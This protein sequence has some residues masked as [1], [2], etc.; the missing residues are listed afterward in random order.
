VDTGL[1]EVL[2]AAPRL[3]VGLEGVANPE[4]VGN[5]FRNAVAFGADAVLL[6][7]HCADPLY[8]KAI[9]VSMGGT[10]R[11]PFAWL[12]TWSTAISQLR[13]SGFTTIA[14]ST[15]SRAV[16]LTELDRDGKCSERIALIFGSEGEGLE[17]ATLG[18][19]DLVVRIPMS[20]A[21][22]S[23]NV[24]TASGVALHHCFGML[25]R[26]APSVPGA[27]A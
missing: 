2:A 27:E 6:S 16:D 12:P 22:D 26:R 14:L 23:L 24:A 20:P 7:T 17:Q 15:S 3:L 25:N 4:N 21:V 9:R 13:A 18:A 1:G 10:L 19:A 8:R 11:T 5:V